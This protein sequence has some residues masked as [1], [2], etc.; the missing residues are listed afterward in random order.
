M[1]L[2]PIALGLALVAIVAATRGQDKPKAK[3]GINK[4]FEHPNVE[5]FIKRFETDTREVYAKRAEIVAALGLKPGMAVADVGAG[6]GF[7]TRLFAER[8]GPNGTVFAVDIAQEFLDHIA[9]LARQKGLGQIKTVRGTQEST[10]LPP[11]SV[12]LAFLCDVY[13]HIEVPSNVLKSIH[14][15]LRPGGALV[16]VEFDRREGVSTPFVLEHVR[17]PKEVFFKEIEDAGF[18]R[19]PLPKPPV[20]KENFIMRFRKV[21]RP[22]AEAKGHR[23]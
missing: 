7:Y 2:R 19:Q 16:V 15:A 20:L 9:A 12:D 11:N 4:Q 18:E 22:P 1:K 8:V 6:T 21:E 13:H 3:P 10:N 14:R 23:S 5:Q 17:A